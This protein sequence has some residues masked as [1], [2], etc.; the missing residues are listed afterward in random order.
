MLTTIACFVTVAVP[1]LPADRP[2]P[3]Q[4]KAGTAELQGT[5]KL[6]SVEVKGE[7][8]ASADRQPRLVIKG[9]KILYAGEELARLTVD[10]QAAPKI[11]DLE[12][13]NP[14]DRHYEAIYTV[15][16]DTL[17]ICLNARTDGVKERPDGFATKG[18]E[19]WRLLVLERDP[20]PKAGLSGF[21][22]VVLRFDKDK[23]A[24]SIGSVFDGSPAKKADLR[25]EDVILRVGGQEVK[26]LVATVEAIRQ[27]K[28]GTALQIRV[29]RDGQ[30]RDI[31]VTVGV[32]PFHF[33]ALLD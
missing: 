26:E 21:V 14:K 16:K 4:A 29:L 8:I 3:G 5:W 30:E 13:V 1:L 24:V 17:K 15:D 31:I 7:V 18:K 10:A 32:M 9:T 22:G 11:M 28:P 20:D 2:V 27:T 33:Y 12:F 6:V 25:A 23:M 19:H